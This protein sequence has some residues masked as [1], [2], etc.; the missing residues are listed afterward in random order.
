MMTLLLML[1]TFSVIDL[2][3]GERQ[4]EGE[5]IDDKDTCENKL[6]NALQK[7]EER[8]NQL[9]TAFKE[10]EGL[11]AALTRVK[12]WTTPDYKGKLPC[13]GRLATR[14]IGLGVTL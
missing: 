12:E 9:A 14:T 8:D 6:V 4:V 10:I 1:D 7:I 2:L 5:I 3:S 13:V 11:K